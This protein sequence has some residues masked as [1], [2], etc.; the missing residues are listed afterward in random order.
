MKTGKYFAVQ[1]PSYVFENSLHTSYV[2]ENNIGIILIFGAFGIEMMV[3]SNA[4]EI[5]FK[6]YKLLNFYYSDHWE[7]EVVRSSQSR[8]LRQFTI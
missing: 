7:P 1:K 2:T 5:V 8:E 4:I 6:S 3:K